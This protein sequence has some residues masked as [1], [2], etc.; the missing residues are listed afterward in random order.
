MCVVKRG[1]IK[2]FSWASTT[3]N[4]WQR[5]L[6]QPAGCGGASM[7]DGVALLST[8]AKHRHIQREKTI[9]FINIRKYLVNIISTMAL[10]EKSID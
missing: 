10:I 7:I 5:Q 4:K 3:N 1:W 6:G 2:S 8:C 9:V